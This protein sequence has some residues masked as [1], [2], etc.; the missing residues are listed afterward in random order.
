MC[1]QRTSKLPASKRQRTAGPGGSG[2]SHV[3]SK[4]SAWA[5]SNYSN[6]G[7]K[8]GSGSGSPAIERP[9]G[10]VSLIK[11]LGIVP[12][13]RPSGTHGGNSSSKVKILP[14]VTVTHSRVTNS[15]LPTGSQQHSSNSARQQPQNGKVAAPAP[16]QQ[17]QDQ[18]E[19]QQLHNKTAPSST[20][21]Q[22]QRQQGTHPTTTSAR[23]PSSTPPAPKPSIAANRVDFG[24]INLSFKPAGTVA[25][26]MTATAQSASAVAAVGS[27]GQKTEEVTVAKFA[28]SGSTKSA[29]QA[30]PKAA[31]PGY[32]LCADDQWQTNN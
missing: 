2:S 30:K 21:N 28:G 8:S 31:L 16:Y 26:P 1:L 19:K 13:S 24:S 25:A 20:P 15:S 3:N 32:G 29:Q 11:Q 7:P 18:K 4:P 6:T 10:Q 14:K 12:I 22:Q 9:K 5:G 23:V 27:R 17:R